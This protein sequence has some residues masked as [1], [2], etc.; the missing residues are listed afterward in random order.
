M[1]KISLFI[2][3][4]CLVFTSKQLNAQA[5]IKDSSIFIT[6][7][8]ISYA[9]QVPFA[10][11][12]DRFGVNSNLG[13]HLNF[14]TK[15]NWL[16]GLEGG[17][18]FGNQ[19]N[20]PSVLS[21][22]RNSDGEIIDQNGEYAKV[23]IYERGFTTTLVGGYLIP[24]LGPN[25]NSGILLK[26][27][28]GFMQHKIKIEAERNPVPQLT[29][30]YLKGYDRLTSGITFQ[31]FIGYQYLSNKRLINFFV[32]I[33]FFEGILTN[34]RSFNYDL[35]IREETKRFDIL[36]GIRA[37]WILPIYVRPPRDVYYN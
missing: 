2:G 30:D 14:K 20:D 21:T 27:G 36:G 1:N 24:K 16:F 11:M 5:S 26:F 7:V 15:K 28:V 17:F 34:R 3:I 37:G 31:Q 25:P 13:F 23:L 18:I 32:G 19:I 4:I 10:E 33:E 29:G 12:S 8:K 9:F 22:L 6:E 35:M